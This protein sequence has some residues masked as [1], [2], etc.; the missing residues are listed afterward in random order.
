MLGHL[1][2]IRELE[3]LG[4]LTIPV[5][6]NGL[7]IGIIVRTRTSGDLYLALEFVGCCL[8]TSSAASAVTVGAGSVSIP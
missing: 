8:S 2:T 6:L 3:C 4:G 7:G 5:V 1:P